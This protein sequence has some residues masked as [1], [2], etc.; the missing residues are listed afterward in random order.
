[1]CTKKLKSKPIRDNSKLQFDKKAEKY[2]TE[3]WD[4]AWKKLEQELYRLGLIKIN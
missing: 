2:L 4:E 3:T 1:M